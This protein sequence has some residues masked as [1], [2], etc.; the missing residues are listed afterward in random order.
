LRGDADDDRGSLSWTEPDVVALY[1]RGRPGWPPELLDALALPSGPKLD[2]AAGTGKLTRMLEPPVV[3]VD[4]SPAMLDRLREHAPHAE[5]RVG[6]ADAIP[7]GDGA[8]AAVLVAE[9]FHWFATDA[10][11]REIARVLRPGGV[12]VVMWNIHLALPGAQQLPS[13]RGLGERRVSAREVRESGAWREP[14]SGV[15]SEPRLIAVE[16]EQRLDAEGWR[17]QVGSWSFV[18]ALPDE[19]RAAVLAGLGDDDV[20]VRYRAEAWRMEKL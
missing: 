7:L 9:A 20:T 14:L 12:L 1:E 6:S 5:A 10:A 4:V 19:Q 3:A 17:A 16:H 11:A 18:A 8:V 13:S 2:L 15:F